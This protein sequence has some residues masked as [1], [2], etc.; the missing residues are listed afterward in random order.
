MEEIHQQIRQVVADDP[1]FYVFKNATRRGS[2]YNFE[3][4]LRRVPIDADFI[5]F[6]DQDDIWY[7]DKL[8]TLLAKFDTETQLVYSDMNLVSSDGQLVSKT[9]WLGR[10]NNYTNRYTLMFSN[11]VTGAASMFRASLLQDIL[12]F[13]EQIGEQYHDHWVALVAAMHGVL[14]FVERPLYAYRQHGGN[15]IGHRVPGHATLFPS[16]SFMKR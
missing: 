10:R 8:E 5:A 14:G 4:A 13:P 1:R 7:P 12:P 16:L 15:V 2:Y 11:T 6:S 9:F 3:E